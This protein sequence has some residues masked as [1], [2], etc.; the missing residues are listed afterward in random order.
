M[1]GVLEID[2]VWKSFGGVKALQGVTL[3]IDSTHRLVGLMGPNGSGKTTL[4]NVITGVYRPD[5][6]DIRLNGRNLVG[7]APWDIAAAGLGRT[8]QIPRVFG[9]LTVEENVLVGSARLTRDVCRRAHELLELFDLASVSRSPA[10]FLSVGQ[11]KLVEL[12]RVLLQPRSFVLLDEV[13]AGLHLDL[14]S[15]IGQYLKR[16]AQ[17]GVCLLLVEHN[18]EFLMETCSYVYVIDRGRIIAHGSPEEVRS[19]ERV[20][21]AYLGP[22][23]D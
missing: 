19:D 18:V 5:R 16:L 17:S 4:F 23:A 6:G 10:R 8:F 7:L 11:Q 22:P 3:R 2:E 13:A 12:A 20:I 21:E 1:E 15:R 14:V 9:E